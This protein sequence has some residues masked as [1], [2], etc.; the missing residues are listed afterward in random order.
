MW[1][2]SRQASRRAMYVR[3]VPLFSPLP[4]PKGPDASPG[5]SNGA[6]STDRRGRRPPNFLHPDL[7]DR[8]HHKDSHN[9]VLQTLQRNGVFGTQQ[10]LQGPPVSLQT[11]RSRGGSR[12]TPYTSW[13]R[14]SNRRGKA[15]LRDKCNLSGVMPSSPGLTTP[16]RF[17]PARAHGLTPCLHMK[18][19][20]RDTSSYRLARGLSCLAPA[21]T[22]AY[23]P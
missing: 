21:P 22:A 9:G 20:Q 2:P 1:C 14:A 13:G 12:R 3:L 11:G 16:T 5:L 15:F 23:S 10:L 6:L 4:C 8:H 7:R 19:R 18:R 17:T